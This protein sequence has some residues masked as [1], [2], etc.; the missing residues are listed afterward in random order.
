MNTQYIT[1]KDS[2]AFISQVVQAAGL[3][4][5]DAQLWA[6]LL[7][8]T[9]LLGFDTHGIRMVERYIDVLAQGGASLK[10]P[11]VVSSKGATALIDAHNC[12]G[13]LAAWKA[14]EITAE[15]AKKH[16]IAFTGIINSGHMGSC[17]LYTKALAERDLI[18]ICSTSSLPGIAP[19]G[20][21]KPTVG[22][23]PVSIAAPAGGDTFFL[24]DMS[25]TVTAMGKVTMAMDNGKTI[26][27]GW[28]LDSK[29]NPTTDPKEAWAGSLL[30][31]GDY[32]GYGLAM[33][34]E[35]LC[36]ALTGG[37]LAA[38]ISSWVMDPKNPP[39]IPFSIMA[40]DI[41]HFQNPENFKSR[42]KDWL[43]KVIDVPKKEGV[44]RIYY[45]GEIE[46]NTFKLRSK[47][48]IPLED[49]T[50]ESFLRLAKKYSLGEP[51]VFK[52]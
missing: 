12:L 51:K 44:E 11:Q 52:P 8:E 45:P 42:V 15:N 39:K 22:I 17:A 47:E 36:S 9:S 38:E 30:P 41:G 1:E 3:S 13:H 35:L 23:N 27:L 19:T 37:G 4:A 33:A 34:I 32:K 24:L 18:G 50:V 16:G 40:I 14:T 48:G 29:G 5:D 46:N 21:I 26:P 49:V 31:I 7:T 20:G 10:Q 2:T 43:K 25:T 6:R 28:A